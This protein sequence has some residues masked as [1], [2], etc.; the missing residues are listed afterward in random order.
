M[1]WPK[2]ELCKVHVGR[3]TVVSCLCQCGDEEARTWQ[4]CL[5]DLMNNRLKNDVKREEIATTTI[6]C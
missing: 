4:V 3:A 1:K 5:V 6:G 2:D